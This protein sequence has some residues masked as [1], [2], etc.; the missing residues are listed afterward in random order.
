VQLNSYV[1]Q[2]S[3]PWGIARISHS[4]LNTA[5]YVYDSSAGSGVCAYVIDT[6]ILTTH[7]VR[8]I[9]RALH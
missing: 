7:N 5:T 3:P 4:T 8:T 9:L 1:T 6:G 2:S